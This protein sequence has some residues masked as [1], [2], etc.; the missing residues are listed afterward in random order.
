MYYHDKINFKFNFALC[1]FRISYQRYKTFKPLKKLFLL[2]LLFIHSII[3]CI[4]YIARDSLEIFSRCWEGS[5]AGDF[6]YQNF[7]QNTGRPVGGA[8]ME[9]NSILIYLSIFFAGPGV[10]RFNYF[11]LLSD[12]WVRD[13][14]YKWRR[15]GYMAD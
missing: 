1:F 7:P 3:M 10:G 13:F 15:C 11:L 6:W 2:V 4:F 12:G 14:F 8:E 9:K 5:I